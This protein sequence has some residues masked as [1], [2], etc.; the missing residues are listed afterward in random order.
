MG[1][2]MPLR[3]AGKPS[4]VFAK[5][6]IIPKPGATDLSLVNSFK[7]ISLLPVI[8]K[9]LESVIILNIDTET[10]LNAQTEQHGFTAGKS[11]H[12]KRDTY[13]EPLST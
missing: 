3:G 9:A 1:R 6:V 11:M 5:L 12:Q 4:L 13:S 2:Y 7:P 8:G 10:T